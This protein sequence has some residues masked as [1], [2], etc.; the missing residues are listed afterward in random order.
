MITSHIWENQTRKNILKVSIE[1]KWGSDMLPSNEDISH[2]RW[3]GKYWI[4][5]II[6]KLQLN[7]Q[8]NLHSKLIQL[9]QELSWS[10]TL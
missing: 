8:L 2:A 9:L 1:K 7:S 10:Y 4:N 6:V 5:M 3:L